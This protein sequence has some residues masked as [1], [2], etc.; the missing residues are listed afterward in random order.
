MSNLVNRSVSSYRIH[1]SWKLDFNYFFLIFLKQLLEPFRNETFFNDVCVLHLNESLALTN[2]GPLSVISI[3]NSQDC[4][5]LKF[6]FVAG[7]GHLKVI[8]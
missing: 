1:P 4:P 8:F 7:W 6:C 5:P 3:G 2:E